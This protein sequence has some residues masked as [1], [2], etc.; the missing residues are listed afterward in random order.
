MKTNIS[1]LLKPVLGLMLVALT[2]TA[3]E[4]KK[5][6]VVTTTAGFRHSSIATAEKVLAKLGQQSGLFTVEYVQQPAGKPGPD[7]QEQLKQSLSKLSRD[8]LKNYDAVIF[9][10]TTGNLPL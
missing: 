4:P 1:I 10:N 2:A 9:A 3:A 7:F 8:N 5:I 6:L